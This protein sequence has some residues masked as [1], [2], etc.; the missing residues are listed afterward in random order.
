MN[1]TTLRRIALPLA[2]KVAIECHWLD[3]DG[4]SNVIHYYLDQAKLPVSHHRGT[5]QLQGSYPFTQDRLKLGCW[6][7]DYRLRVYYPRHAK[8]KVPNG[9]FKAPDFKVTYTTRELLTVVPAFMVRALEE[10]RPAPVWSAF[11]EVYRL[12]YDGKEVPSD[13]VERIEAEMKRSPVLVAVGGGQE[14]ITWN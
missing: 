13:L 11:A 10:P 1:N 4:M 3:N 14:S 12:W 6:T 7:I 8:A 9:I 2:D 5:A